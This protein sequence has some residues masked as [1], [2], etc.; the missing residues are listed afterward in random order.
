MNQFILE[1]SQMD[2]SVMKY[3]EETY[4]PISFGLLNQEKD[5]YLGNQEKK[6]CRFCR[7]GEEAVKFEHRAHVF[8]ESIGNRFLLSY[9]ECDT[10]NKKFSR[11]LENHYSNFFKFYHNASNIRGKKTVPTYQTKTGKS[12]AE[13]RK[14]INGK[15]LYVISDEMDNITTYIDIEEKRLLRQ[16][17]IDSYIPMAVYKC[18][19]KMA[20]SVMPDSELMYFEKTLDWISSKKHENIFNGKKLL[21]RYKIIPGFG[22]TKFPAYCLYKRKEQIEGGLLFEPYMLF[23]LTYGNFSYLIEVPTIRYNTC[24][25]IKKLPFPPIPFVTSG[26]GIYD[27]SESVLCE[28]QRCSM[29]YH[30]DIAIPIV[31]GKESNM[32]KETLLK[33]MWLK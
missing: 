24:I 21:C 33:S 31:E 15:E 25:D 26:E 17:I 29:E 18:F 4:V 12:R 22:T 9:Y 1:L 8:P 7:K 2:D 23:N 16:G 3:Y 13:W 30:F 5:T 19:V 11:L 10:C 27:F 32:D 20:L 28:N 14:D 6:V